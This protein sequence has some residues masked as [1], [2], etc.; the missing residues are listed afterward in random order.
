MYGDIASLCDK[1]TETIF[2]AD[3][4]STEAAA[5]CSKVVIKYI[6]III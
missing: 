5:V 2:G 1:R 3:T 6:F 4:E